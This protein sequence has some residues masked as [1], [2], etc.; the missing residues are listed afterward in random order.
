MEL[1]TVFPNALPSQTADCSMGKLYAQTV[2]LWFRILAD[3]RVHISHIN[4][5]FLYVK[6]ARLL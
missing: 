1:V 6:A 2:R 4:S 5:T 3:L